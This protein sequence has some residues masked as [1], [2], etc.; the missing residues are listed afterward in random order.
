M[1]IHT[2]FYLSLY[3]YIYINT[4]I[5]THGRARKRKRSV[6]EEETSSAG[7]RLEVWRLGFWS[8]DLTAI[9]PNSWR[10]SKIVKLRLERVARRTTTNLR[11]CCPSSGREPRHSGSGGI[12]IRVGL[13]EFRLEV[14]CFSDPR[15]NMGIAVSGKSFEFRIAA[16]SFIHCFGVHKTHSR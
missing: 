6:T 15:E 3:I 2:Y 16:L 13:R 1:Y 12:P 10:L 14:P 5:L 8:L 4:Y 11:K 7:F 9:I